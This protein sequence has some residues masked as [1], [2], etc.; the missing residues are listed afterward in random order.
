MKQLRNRILMFAVIGLTTGHLY[1]QQSQTEIATA[2]EQAYLDGLSLMDSDP[3]GARAEFEQAARG[4]KELLDN[5]AHS[6]GAWFNLGNALLR[7][8]RVGEAIV[9]YRRAERID[10]SND[11]VAANLAVARTRVESRIEPDANNMSFSNVASWWHPVSPATR[12][13]IALGCWIG[14][15][16]LLSLR[17]SRRRDDQDQPE[18]EFARASWLTGI[19]ATISIAVIAAG[20]LLFDTAFA[21]MYPVGVITNDQI[22][23]RSGNGDGFA[24]IAEEPLD[25]GVEFTILESR[26]GWWRIELADGTVGWI[27]AEDAQAV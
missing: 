15:W 21:N 23:L 17:C 3:T 12:L 1:A 24:A 16:V 8:D 5:G 19:W 25:E 6:S 22:V 14:F 11:D 20:T 26:P 7:S 13:W 10:P 4:Y 27:P 18:S 9:A 2:A